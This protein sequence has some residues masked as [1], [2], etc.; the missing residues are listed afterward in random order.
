MRGGL[1]VI[2]ARDARSMH[3]VAADRRRGRARLASTKDRP[4]R[5][6]LAADLELGAALCTTSPPRTSSSARRSAPPRRRS[7]PRSCSPCSWSSSRS[8]TA[9]LTSAAPRPELAADL[10]VGSARSALPRLRPTR[11]RLCAD[12]RR[13]EAVQSFDPPNS[14]T[15]SSASSA[16]W[17]GFVGARFHASTITRARSRASSS[18][19]CRPIRSTTSRSSFHG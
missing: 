4:R 3:H 11:R 2:S 7:P 10:E 15:R 17:S 6:E 12:W 9:A 5:P 1:F 14:S 13:M 19:S 18:A 8:A 16:P